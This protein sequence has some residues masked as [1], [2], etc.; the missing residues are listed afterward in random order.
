MRKRTARMAWLVAGGVALG[1]L[2]I[3]A[4]SY[5]MRLDQE[6]LDQ[7]RGVIRGSFELV[8]QDGRG[9][10]EEMAAAAGTYLRSPAPR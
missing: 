7:Q 10:T 9:V 8:D 3:A 4:T 6:S 2:A 1:A 5:V